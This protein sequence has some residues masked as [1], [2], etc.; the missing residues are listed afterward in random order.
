[1]RSTVLKA[2]YAKILNDEQF[3]KDYPEK[4]NELAAKEIT[5]DTFIIE[6]ASEEVEKLRDS[7]LPEDIKM[8]DQITKNAIGQSTTPVFEWLKL[9]AT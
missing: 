8:L 7:T 2:G 6:L 1:M 5:R 4:F 3:A 9:N